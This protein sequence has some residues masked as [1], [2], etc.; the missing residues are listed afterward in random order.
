MLYN[1]P[2]PPSSSSIHSPSPSHPF[3]RFLSL[4]FFLFSFSRYAGG[5]TGR[6][7]RI[8]LFIYFFHKKTKIVR[9]ILRDEEKKKEEEMKKKRKNIG[10]HTSSSNILQSPFPWVRPSSCHRCV[11]KYDTKLLLTSS[12]LSSLLLL[13]L[14]LLSL[15][16]SSGYRWKRK[17]YVLC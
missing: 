9:T 2:F 17:H 7:R 8:Y 4:S 14:L 15:G 12:S 5:H 13:L 3:L 6:M 1:S 11:T 16:C 10:Y